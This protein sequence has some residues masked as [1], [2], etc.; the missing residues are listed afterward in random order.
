M[1][2][3]TGQG[4]KQLRDDYVFLGVVTQRQVRVNAV[5]V[6]TAGLPAGYITCLLKV[7]DDLVGGSFSDPDTLRNLASGARRVL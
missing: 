2:V 1:K 5:D 4:F 3:P 7:G 6:A